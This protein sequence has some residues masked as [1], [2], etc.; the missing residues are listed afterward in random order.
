NIALT[1]C[2]LLLSLSLY[3]QFDTVARKKAHEDTITQRIVLIGDAG[4]LTNGHHPVVDAVR[5]LITLDKKTTVLFLGDNVYK[6]G[7]PD[8]QA[9]N[10]AIDRAVLDSQ[11]SVADGTDA[12]VFMIPGNHDWQNGS[13]GGYDAIL[14]QGYYVDILRKSNNV[15]YYPA[16]GCPGPVEVSLGNDVTLILFDSQWWLH[17][18]DKPEIESDCP[19]KTKEELVTQI[20]EIAAR[21]SKKLILLACH[22]PFKS[23]GVH[24]G[25]FTLK[26]HIFP[27]TDISSK[28]YIPLPI[29][30][31]IYPIARS[32]FGTPQDLAHPNYQDMIDKISTVIKAAAPNVVFVAGHEHNLEHIKDS[33]YNYII[34]GGGCKDQ[35]VSKSKKSLFTTESMGFCVMEVSTNKNVT[36]QYYTVTDSVRNPYNATLL[37]FSKL[38]TAA[39][40]TNALKVDDPFLKYKDTFTTAAS[41]NFPEVKGLRKFFTGQNYRQ[42]WS[43][44]VN[45]KVFNINK[46]KGG[47]T[48]TGM[49]GGSETKTLKL[50]QKKTGKEW[51]LRSLNKNAS[52]TVPENFRGPLADQLGTEL[53]SASHPYG[54]LIFPGL[55][56]SLNLNVPKP[57]LFFVPDDPALGY[58]RPL[59]A[60]NVCMLE[61][62]DATP[63]KS[64]SKTT[65]KLFSKMLDEND[66]LPYQLVVLKARLL[67]ILT[68]DF[69]RHFDQWRWGTIDTGKGKIYYPI[70]RDRD[71]AFFYSDGFILK[72]LS[73]RSMPFLK[74]FRNNIPKV[75]WLGYSARDFDRLFLT[76]LDE[77]QWRRTIANFQ[78]SLS[79][80]AIR[81]AVKGMPPEIVAI[82]GEKFTHKMISRRDK[83]PVEAM[84][85][86]KFISKKV[87]VVG[88][89]LREYFKV[90]NY[91]EGL[92]VRVYAIARG[93]DTSFIMYNRIF[94]PSVTHEIRLYGLNDDDVFNVE[95]NASSRIKLRIIGGKGY[96]TFDIKGHIETLLYDLKTA[97]S[98][99]GNY[100]KN[101]SNAKVR[102]SFDPPVNDRSILGFNYNTTKLPRLHL[103][104]NSD[105]GLMLGAGISKR[106]Y[107]FRNLPYATDQR[108]SVLYAIN[109]KAYQFNYRGEFN[110]LTRSFDLVLKGNF[111]N[112]ALRNF[113][114]F[115]N[116]PP[117]DK[118]R[119]FD[120]YLTR[121]RSVELE[122]LFR[123]RFFEKVSL[124]AGPYFYHYNNKFSDNTG[125]ILGNYRQVGLDS[126]DIFSK[127]NYAGAKF[128]LL[129]D[130]T[131]KEFFPTRGVHWDNQLTALTGLTKGSDDYIKFNTDMSVYAS[132]RQEAKLL[133]ILKIGWA[134]IFTNKYEYFQAMTIGGN[135]ALNGFRKN[136]F[137]GTTS[138]YSSIELKIK[139]FDINS[140]LLPGRVGLTTFYDIGRVW[141]RAGDHSGTWHGAYG[142]GI[143]FMP[144]DLFILSATAGFADGQKMFNFTLGTRINLTY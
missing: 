59:F 62:K 47:F 9:T 38:P 125:N 19:Y 127:K 42:E 89:N 67:D 121:Y 128:A 99:T 54:A 10:Y 144:F 36:I 24:G 3:S 137:S 23:N 45:M 103:N 80:S 138:F 85:Y 53:N 120:Y 119:N 98:V 130:N 115:G 82:D 114:G 84:K 110:H 95:E 71:Q 4:Q 25:L 5:N 6:D 133:A 131:N 109:R 76:D 22:H 108:L 39:L 18:Y 83:M 13:P 94:D 92:Q 68:G 51:V 20:G 1:G 70:P 122:A 48:I 132:L 113:T 87:N 117:V 31:S 37:N 15:H 56:K 57:E 41:K 60:N 30:G 107:G 28:A 90:S 17:P 63:D 74:G 50:T 77:D 65:A 73:G 96:D 72:V 102:F 143:Y 14:R 140:F 86:Y 66:H 124:L 8:D 61:E 26:Q 126:A 34:S 11:I 49:G 43:T 93:S 139:L 135:N 112:P 134:H 52:K 142:G 97:D 16:D 105:D 123:K 27:F 116:N 35:R 64:D 33:I 79:D 106:T 91:G 32:V 104:Y 78:E 55:A 21:N 81:N 129:L 7:L 69:D 40:D 75:N 100:I 58:F 101:K 12:K 46:E 44:P 111:S 141:L 136:R 118:A 29:I 2:L 88:S